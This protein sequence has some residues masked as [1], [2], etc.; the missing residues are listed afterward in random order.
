[1]EDLF[2]T[3]PTLAPTMEATTRGGWT[4]E[5]Y[6]EWVRE[7]HSVVPNAST[8]AFYLYSSWSPSVSLGEICG[9]PTNVVG[10]GS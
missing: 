7:A 1:M 4:Y 5:D 6:E 10:G 2:D 8:G 9:M 3:S